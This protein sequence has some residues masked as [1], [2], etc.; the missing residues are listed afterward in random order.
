VPVTPPVG[1]GLTPIEL[2]SVE[3]SGIPIGETEG[4]DEIPSGEVAPI[5]GVGVADSSTCAMARLQTKR[6]ETA[7]AINRDLMAFSASRN[8]T[9]A[10][11]PMALPFV[12]T[13]A[14]RDWRRTKAAQPP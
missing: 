2:I 5:V 11:R 4:V 10:R 12:P 3:S 13:P 9:S 8:A 6:A 1:V 14:K 7:A